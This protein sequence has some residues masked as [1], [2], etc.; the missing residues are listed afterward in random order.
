MDSFLLSGKKAVSPNEMHKIGWRGQDV[1]V[2]AKKAD[3]SKVSLSIVCQGCPRTS[4]ARCLSIT[5]CLKA[6]VQVL[7]DCLC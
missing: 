2:D 3:P 1:W 6:C 7:R 5:R 4:P